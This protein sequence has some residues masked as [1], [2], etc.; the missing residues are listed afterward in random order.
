MLNLVPG[1]S[2]GHRERIMA[3]LLLN[4][5]LSRSLAHYLCANTVLSRSSLQLFQRAVKIGVLNQLFKFYVSFGCEGGAECFPVVS[6]TVFDSRIPF[7]EQRKDLVHRLAQMNWID[8]RCMRQAVGW[9]P[10]DRAGS[11]V[12]LY[13]GTFRL[14]RRL[15][16]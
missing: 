15:R 2:V 11:P 5:R 7:S 10:R 3:L 9:L 13:L 14:R 16:F 1:S 12:E 4:R 6:H 8:R